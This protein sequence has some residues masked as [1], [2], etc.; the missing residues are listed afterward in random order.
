M[1]MLRVVVTFGLCWTCAA[2]TLCP[3]Y[4]TNHGGQCYFFSSDTAAWEQAED[5][6]R[7]IGGHL[8]SI[9][10]NDEQSWLISQIGQQHFWIGL[11]DRIQEG[12]WRWTDGSPLAFQ[13][14]YT[15]EPNNG[16]GNEHCG[17]MAGSWASGHWNDQPCSSTLKYICKRASALCG[18]APGWRTYRDD[19]F[20]FS[21]ETTQWEVAE[22]TCLSMG[23]HLAS[24]RDD[25]EQSWLTSQIGQQDFWIGL[26]DQI[27]EGEWKWTDGSPYDHSLSNWNTPTDEPNNN[28]GNE[29]CGQ[30]AGSW[31]SGHWND[32]T[33]STK[34]KYI[35]KRANSETQCPPPTC[36]DPPICHNCPDPITCPTLPTPTC[37]SCPATTTCAPLP[38]GPP[39]T[40]PTLETST[41]AQPTNWEPEI[42]TSSAGQQSCSSHD[43]TCSCLLA[44]AASPRGGFKGVLNDGLSVNRSIAIRGRVGLNAD[45]VI[46]N[47]L[48]GDLVADANGEDD[49][50]TALHIK[51]DFESRT[52]TLNSKVDNL[53]GQKQIKVFPEQSFPFGPGLDFKIVIRCEADAFHTTF[54]D[55]HQM[56]YNYQVHDLRRVKWLEA[57]QVSL[58][59]IQLM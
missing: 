11:A 2:L 28:G 35:C 33:C 16:G 59:G 12:N 47:L 29:N 54:N 26:T 4:W 18:G 45:R 44:M 38:T 25:S 13:D 34:L 6:C 19:C 55:L 41:A 40:C 37:P 36:P 24:I 51:L 32:L 48:A 31:A 9:W 58:T 53:W 21:R 49:N 8:A 43:I 15:N 17:E 14:W 27:R 7:S 3:P 50:T 22:D 39:P 42:C 23:A 5:T 46:V 52:I 57:W 1:K 30:M 10:D 20:Y 56:A